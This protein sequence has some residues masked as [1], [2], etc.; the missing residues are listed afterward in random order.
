MSLTIAPR[1]TVEHTECIAQPSAERVQCPYC[2]KVYAGGVIV[3][4]ES[5]EWSCE[6]R[7]FPLFRRFYCDHCDHL[8]AWSE[9]SDGAGLPT[10]VVLDGPRIT[11]D[12]RTVGVFL[13]Q[14]PQSAGVQQS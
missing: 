5:G 8:I 3:A 13:R 6:H 10:G 9:A 7:C 4:A 11:A 12:R 1:T 2:E 14:Y